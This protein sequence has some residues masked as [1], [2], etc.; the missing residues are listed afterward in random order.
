MSLSQRIY[1]PRSSEVAMTSV[2]VDHAEV[3]PL[4]VV[5]VYP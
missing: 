2:A 4:Q 3:P 1:R 5:F